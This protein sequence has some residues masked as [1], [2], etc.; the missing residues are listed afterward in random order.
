MIIPEEGQL[1]LVNKPYQWTSFD[2]VNKLKYGLRAKK[3]GHAGT[4]DPLATGLLIIGI[5][6]FTKKLNEI[7]GL[8]KEYVGVFELGKTTP[9]YDLETAFDSELPIEGIHEEAI[10]QA[11]VALTG[12][13]SQVPPAHSAIKVDGQRAYKLARRKQEVVLKSRQVTIY[14]F[15][16]MEIRLP[17]VQ[18]RISCSKGTYIRSLAHDFGKLLGVGAYLKSLERTRVGEFLLK[19]AYQLEELVTLKKKD[20]EDH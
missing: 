9:S 17:E 13:L 19:D 4:L 12:Q 10:R 7:Q 6:K 16:I 2:V 8:D 15:E 20:N 3:I 5:N 14:E 1:L 11:A 18:V